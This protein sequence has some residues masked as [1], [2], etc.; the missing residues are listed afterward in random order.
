M[1]RKDW[2]EIQAIVSMALGILTVFSPFLLVIFPLLFFSPSSF[3]YRV[4]SWTPRLELVETWYGDNWSC[5]MYYCLSLDTA[6][7]F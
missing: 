7:A 1:A 3:N 2:R 5:A 6:V 4:N